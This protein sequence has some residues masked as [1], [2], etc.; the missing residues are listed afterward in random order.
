MGNHKPGIDGVHQL[1]KEMGLGSKQLSEIASA[2]GIKPNPHFVVR[3]DQVGRIKECLS[4]H[5]YEAPTDSSP[6]AQNAKRLS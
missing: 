1:A 6:F 4:L 3:V 5:G 2:I